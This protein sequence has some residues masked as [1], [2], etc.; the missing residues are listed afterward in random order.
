MAVAESIDNATIELL[1]EI[2]PVLMQKISPLIT[3]FKAVG[4]VL[5]IY[6]GYL[7]IKAIIGLRHRNR[8][9]NIEKKV[10]EIDKKLDLLLKKEK[11]KK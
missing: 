1:N 6:F 9:K 3:I 5:I 2:S 10:E 8:V 7:I 4:I 11:K